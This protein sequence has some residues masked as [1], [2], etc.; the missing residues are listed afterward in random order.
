[1]SD[2]AKKYVKA[3][4]ES[5]D[6]KDLEVVANSIS[7]IVPVF[8]DVKLKIILFAND[9]SKEE[10]LN[11]LSS[12]IKDANPKLLNLFKILAQNNRLDLIPTISKELNER[13]ANILNK[14]KGL[15]YSKKR[16]NKNTI[17][18][19]AT[20]LSK[21]YNT[22]IELDNIVCDY[23]GIKVDIDTLGIEVAF[24]SDRLK[25]DLKDYILKS[26]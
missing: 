5:M 18:K 2:I 22:E 20:N 11:L 10:K 8:K 16:I 1:M 7:E 19:I 4:I 14:H 6:S 12:M 21:K 13:V 24:S 15:V 26:I 23:N 9:I 25:D 17:K 3:L